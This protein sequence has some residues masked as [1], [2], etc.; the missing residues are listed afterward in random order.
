MR[1]KCKKRPKND[2]NPTRLKMSS[3]Q[4]FALGNFLKLFRRKSGLRFKYD[5]DK[6]QGQKAL[7]SKMLSSQYIGFRFHHFQASGSRR[8]QM[9]LNGGFLDA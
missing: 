2:T 9:K 8:F 1:Q 6:M 7:V 5:P 4:C 3:R